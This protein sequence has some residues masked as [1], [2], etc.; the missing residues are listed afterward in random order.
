M[1]IEKIV[2]GALGTNTYIVRDNDL[3]SVIDPGGNS[4]EILNRIKGGTLDKILL[5]HG[6]FDHIQA[7]DEIRR[8]T[9]AKIYISLEDSSM[10][11]D[12][13][14]SLYSMLGMGNNGFT[15]F[16]AD[17]FYDEE[18]YICQNKFKVIKTPGHSS[19]SVCFLCDNILFSGDTLFC[20]SIGRFDYGNYDTI[21]N[22]LSKLMLLDDGV[23]VYPGH[24]D[25]TTIG[26][27]RRDN[28]FLV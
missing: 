11:K 17:F 24:G 12:Y 26:R 14:K 9:G 19:G 18:I 28:P 3:I 21:M 8:K 10:T 20:G 5:T 27:E 7:A 6:H 16:I 13:D 23:M 25:T 4:D 1:N 2:V 15:S 22:S